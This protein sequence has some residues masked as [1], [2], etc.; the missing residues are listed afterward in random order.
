MSSKALTVKSTDVEVL[1]LD[2]PTVAQCVKAYKVINKKEQEAITLIQEASGTEKGK[3]FLQLK[4]ACQKEGKKWEDVA[5]IECGVGVSTADRYIK[6]FKSQGNLEKLK[7]I[8]TGHKAQIG[9]IKEILSLD[10]EEAISDLKLPKSAKAL[11]ALKGVDVKL[12]TGKILHNAKKKGL[13]I[14]KDRAEDL[15]EKI[16]VLVK[17]EAYGKS[18]VDAKIDTLKKG[19]LVHGFEFDDDDNL[20]KIGDDTP[21]DKVVMDA[22]EENIKEY[23]KLMAKEY[24][25][26]Q[27][28]KLKRDTFFEEHGW[29]AEK[30]STYKDL[31]SKIAVSDALA[32][33]KQLIGMHTNWKKVYREL[34]NLAHPDKGGSTDLQAF[35][36]GLNSVMN[37]V[38][39]VEKLK[40]MRIEK[41]QVVSEYNTWLVAQ[42]TDLPERL[43]EILD[44]AMVNL[45]IDKKDELV[46]EDKK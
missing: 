35:I 46:E 40:I 41:Q 4:A 21:V 37:K 17:A 13:D 36:N 3:I 25:D 38:P 18:Q 12:T 1:G 33:A 15:A 9:P 7:E 45:G 10:S 31:S 22:M 30:E 24:L 32:L 26:L 5:K 2:V 19:F 8:L 16:N 23:K 6:L 42:T 11:Q 44:E 14:D 28:D 29:T 27:K 43:S 34:S 39:D 20:K